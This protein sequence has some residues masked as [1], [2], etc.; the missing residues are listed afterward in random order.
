MP[1][2]LIGAFAAIA[3]VSIAVP[4]LVRLLRTRCTDG[5][6]AT[7][8]ALTIA[9]SFC[10]GTYGVLAHLPAEIACNAAVI[11]VDVAVVTAAHRYGHRTIARR[12]VVTSVACLP[13]MVGAVVFGPA[14]AAFIAMAVGAAQF[15]PH[16]HSAA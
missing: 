9:N 14:V 15:V 16:A 2:E 8:W 12:T 5:M 6:A 13:I 11:V 7:A 3:S 1:V 10:W 4:Q